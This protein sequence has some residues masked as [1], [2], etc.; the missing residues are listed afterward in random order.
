MRA[1][2]GSRLDT[3]VLGIRDFR[4]LWIG[5]SVSSIGDMI[6]P[7]AVAVFVLDAGGGAG[8]VGLVLAA[9]FA[10]L[11][12]F[13]LFG[14]VW[15]DRLPRTR[16]M[17]GADLLRAVAVLGLALVPG[18]P[19]V[20]VLA[21]LTFLVGGGEA[22]FRPAFGAILPTIVPV[23]RL[24]VANSLSS[25][26]MNFARVVGPGLV[27]WSRRPAHAWPSWSTRRPSV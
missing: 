26:S 7:V 16:V 24:A 11:V 27:C 17:I 12:L 22:F 18:T 14:G 2:L 25:T 19:A 4:L 13:S 9:R 21:L 20:A 5:Q 1:R 3:S 23:E 6:F 8:D 15:A 10:A